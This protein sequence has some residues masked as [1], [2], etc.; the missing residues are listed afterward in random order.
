MNFNSQNTYQHVFYPPLSIHDFNVIKELGHGAH[1]SVYLVQYKKTNSIYALKT[2]E[3]K[4]FQ[5]KK[6]KELDY[7]REKAILY[8]VM[9]RNNINSI[10]IVKLYRDF[11]DSHFKYLVMEFVEGTNL[12][13]LRGYDNPYGYV[14]QNYYK[15][16][17]FCMM[18]AMLFIEILNQ[19]IYF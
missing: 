2:Y 10:N 17:S 15:H 4:A 5:M 9:Q 19:I 18:N 13:D 8:D 14:S 12:D 1:G 7:K 16:Y 11:E 3:Q 6:L